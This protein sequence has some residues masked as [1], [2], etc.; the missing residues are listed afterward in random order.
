MTPKTQ[1][2]KEKKYNQTHKNLKKSSECIIKNVKKTIYKMGKIF[3]N[4]I[5][6]KGLV[7]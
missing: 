5:S 1:E 4:Y 3:A 6:D 7:S 2:T